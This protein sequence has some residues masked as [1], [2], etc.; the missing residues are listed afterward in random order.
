LKCPSNRSTSGGGTKP[1]RDPRKPQ[2]RKT[3]TKPLTIAR[4]VPDKMK[5]GALYLSKTSLG[6]TPPD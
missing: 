5:M 2:A 4:T 1:E 3:S 6:A